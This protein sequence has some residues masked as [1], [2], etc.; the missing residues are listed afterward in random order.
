MGVYE[1]LCGDHFELR[2]DGCGNGCGSDCGCAACQCRI[3][4]YGPRQR[5][6]CDSAQSNSELLY[7]H[8]EDYDRLAVGGAPGNWSH[9]RGAFVVDPRY[10]C[11]QDTR[12]DGT[13]RRNGGWGCQNGY[14][15]PRYDRYQA[16]RYD[17]AQRYQYQVD[18]RLRGYDDRSNYDYN[19]N[20]ARTRQYGGGGCGGY[21]GYD[22]GYDSRYGRQY[23]GRYGA[24]Y[25]GYDSNYGGCNSG[26]GGG[27]FGGGGFG[28]Q[29]LRGMIASQLGGYRGYGGGYGGFRNYGGYG[30][31]GNPFYNTPGGAIGSIIG[32]AILSGR[33]HR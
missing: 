31:Y 8:A 15:E 32:Q 25:G 17:D 1:Q 13:A 11:F 19:Y 9:R 7:T 24:Q 28:Q 14:A 21:G 27:N 26:F 4:Q 12:Y 3:E 6:Q 22:G 5:S 18:Q 16:A 20:Y 10:E 30:G 2:R 33:H 29:V 23:G